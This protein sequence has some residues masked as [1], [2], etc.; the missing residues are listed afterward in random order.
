MF[1]ALSLSTVRHFDLLFNIIMNCV[2]YSV[3]SATCFV[4]SFIDI[5]NMYENLV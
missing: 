1:S 3:L 5:V 2:T 4:L